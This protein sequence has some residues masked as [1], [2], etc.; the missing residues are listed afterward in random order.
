MIISFDPMLPVARQLFG[1]A[2]SAPW[3]ADQFFA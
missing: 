1:D 2:R 3:A